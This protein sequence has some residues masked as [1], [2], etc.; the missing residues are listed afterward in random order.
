MERYGCWQQGFIFL[1]FRHVFHL[2][3]VYGGPPM[4]GPVLH[5]QHHVGW[6]RGGGGGGKELVAL[7]IMVLLHNDTH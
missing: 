5:F 6:R 4:V 7:L 2:V 3:V 1:V